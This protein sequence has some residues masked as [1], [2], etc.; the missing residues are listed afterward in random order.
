MLKPCLTALIAAIIATPA[1]A[2]SVMVY[3]A[4][5]GTLPTDQCWQSSGGFTPALAAG[6]LDFGSSSTGATRF[7]T[8]NDLTSLDFAGRVTATF[9][10]FVVSGAYASN[11]CGAGQRA[12]VLFGVN[13]VQ[14]RVCQVGLG[15]DRVY[16]TTESNGFAGAS[17]PSAA[18]N[19]A[20]QYRDYRLEINNFT[21][22]VFIDDVQVVTVTRASWPSSGQATPAIAI[23]G[24]DASVC[25]PGHGKMQRFTVTALPSGTST[26]GI[27]VNSPPTTG[28]TCPGGTIRLS[29]NASSPSTPSYRWE[30]NGVD[31]VNGTVPG[32]PS[33]IASGTDAATLVMTNCPRNMQGQFRVRIVNNCGTVTTG[34]VGLDVTCDS[35]ADVTSL[36]SLPG[37]DG[38]LTVDDIIVFLSAFFASDTSIADVARIGGAIGRDG[39][40]T[41]DDVI[42]FLGA[43][44][45]GCNV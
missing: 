6:E 41:A 36:G 40:L 3:D 9:R 35:I 11:P 2:Q 38:Q 15:S 1:F 14:G 16:I 30:L 37:C 39:Q 17:N 13:D 26:G 8:R 5:S 12:G 25:V 27:V 23:F 20:G 29:V 42:A 31:L 18:F 21:A 22:T 19:T 43:F 28:R 10:A 7:Y 44:F 33:T 24:G 34:A 32:Y 45:R 4:A